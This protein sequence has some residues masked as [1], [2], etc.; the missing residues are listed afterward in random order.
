MSLA[1]AAGLQRAAGCNAGVDG[2]AAVGRSKVTRSRAVQHVVCAS[3]VHTIR[4][5]SGARAWAR[6]RGSFSGKLV[7]AARFLLQRVPFLR[8]LNACWR[9]MHC[10]LPL[11]GAR[12][13]NGLPLEVRAATT[14]PLTAAAL[15]HARSLRPPPPPCRPGESQEA[16][17]E[18]G[19]CFEDSVCY[20]WCC[21]VAVER[22]ERD[23]PLACW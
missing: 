19:L 9:A 16:M 14:R 5:V 1:A 4:W 7:A 3:N 17:A 12:V 2:I 8:A 6:G 11:G 15:S 18:V 10:M 23:Q 20:C 21:W 13:H 22:I